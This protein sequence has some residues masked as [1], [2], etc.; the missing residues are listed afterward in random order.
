MVDIN[1]EQIKIKYWVEIISIFRTL[2]Y[3]ANVYKQ[4]LKNNQTCL[5]FYLGYILRRNVQPGQ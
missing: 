2:H 1:V 5:P 4:N 3:I